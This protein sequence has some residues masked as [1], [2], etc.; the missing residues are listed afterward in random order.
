MKKRFI[1]LIDFS[2][3]SGNLIQYACVWA[4]QE[5]AEILVVHE[6][7]PMV[8]G[9]SDNDTREIIIKD[10]NS[11]ALENL[12]TLVNQFLPPGLKANYLVSE[13][14]LQ[15]TLDKLAE[16]DFEDLVFTGLKES[17]LFEKYFLKS[18]V[19]QLIENTNSIIVAMPQEINKYSH[20]NIFVAVSE[21][22]Q[23]NILEFN[24][25]LKFIDEKNTKITFFYLAKPNEDTDE[26]ER[27]LR[28][29]TDLFADRFNTSFE[30]Y[31]ANNP[32]KDIKKVINNKIDEILV[33]Q[34]GSRL[35]SDQLFRRFLINDLVHQ[36]ETPLVIL[37]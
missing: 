13:I 9:F 29:L 28:N 33:V 7:S 16:D 2:E 15:L 5:N 20:E 32:K 4:V 8:P 31:E 24:N 10:T 1:I 14:H 21:K 26:F 36:G 35:L 25:F 22:T 11:E 30:I 18:K 17:G 23:L 27:Q 12:K 37:P 6:T 19:L 34:R 3:L